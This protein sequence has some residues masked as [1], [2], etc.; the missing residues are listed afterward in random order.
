MILNKS[1]IAK[2]LSIAIIGS[3]V[4]LMGCEKADTASDSAVAETVQQQTSLL[5]T[6]SES[7]EAV[8]AEMRA[9]QVSNVSY[10]LSVTIDNKSESFSG[11]TEL[12]FDLVENNQNDLTIDFDEG[13]IKSLKVNGKVVKFSYEKWFITIPASELT[14]GK[15]SITIDYQR[16][17]STDGSGFHRFVD[18]KNGEVYLYTDFEPYDANRLFPHFDQPD[19]KASYEIQV[20]APAHWQI[21]SATRE[22][23][24]SE[25]G[26][27]K[28]WSF[29]ASARFSSYVFSLHAG[30]YAVW[31]DDFEGMKLRLFAR[32]SLAEYVK[33]DEWFIPTKQSFAFF[34]KYFDVQYPF[35]KYD[36]IV[37][38]DFNAGAMENVAAVTFNEGY[39]AR[40]EKST[41]ARMSLANVIAHE[42]AHM[43]FGDLVTMRWW[44]GLWLN[45]SFATYMANLA[46]A[47][48]SDFENNWDVFY[49][50]T[51]QWAYRTDDSV[52]THAI[53]LPVASTGVALSNFDGITYGKGASVLKQL[54][55]YLGEENFRIG[56]SNYL[57]KFSYQNTDLEDFIGELG[58]AAGKDMTQWTQDWLY[59]AGLNTIKVNYQCSDDKISAFAI[60]QTAPEGYPTLREQRVQIG[61]YNVS[62][63]GNAM[64]LTSATPIM[65]KGATTEI[66]A[67]IGQ[68]CPDLVYPNEADWGYVK[69]D[70]DEKSLASAQQHINA[71]DNPTMRLM[72]WQSL[73][74]SVNDAN[75]AADQLVTF[76]MANIE[77]ES[78][79]NV[80]RK[81]ASTLTSALGFLTVATRLEQKDY[82]A[83]Y[84]D[85]ENLYLRLL[86][87][88]E[89]G[90]DFQKLWY[91]RY[92]SV[93]KTTKHLNRLQNILN[94]EKSFDGITI[95]QD[96]RWTLIAKM[97]RYQHGNYQALLNTEAKKDITDSGVKSAIYAEVIRPEAE[98]KEKWF[99]IVINN[100]D[101][102]KLSTLRYIMWGLF[103][104]EQQA[105]E[106]PYK[107]KILAHI[108]KLNEGSDLGLLE[109]F[110]GSML[111]TQCNA[112]SE[113]ELAQLIKDY[114][115]MKP[116]VLKTV[117]ASHQ[118]IGRCV[119]AL[120]LLK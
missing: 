86:E 7:L 1:Q 96:K 72:L 32:Q 95:D 65:Y 28:V 76:A 9:K 67:V 51:K 100:P 36:Q 52:N 88:A 11:S 42:M 39:I 84:M 34:N 44:N 83:L 77:G 99:N 90:S 2:A 104:G 38:P 29:P 91:G 103:P 85:V 10:K 73:S 110:A 66:K 105:L 109:S 5:R 25:S 92:V 58:K 113:A 16:P 93:T 62:A 14:A 54:P 79:Y 27:N 17:Y 50:G 13:T 75:L 31:E 80:S 107:A 37:A 40:G 71:I 4:A 41:S 21:I 24:I 53:E 59:N 69:V 118:Q 116:Q 64:N 119:K 87:N 61:L 115:G 18:P 98:V 60:N 97:N 43:W 82:T 120:E 63:D 112:V 117:K 23:T 70:L 46:I 55:Y 35:G 47:E 101:K 108:P 30:N 6:Q 106:A 56:V 48:A 89:A 12:L 111:P 57:K 94:G 15:Q 19:L 81:I 20:T 78:D 45:E 8:Y 22:T 102:L 74:D 68:A 114:S 3:S 26:D 49:S 33:T